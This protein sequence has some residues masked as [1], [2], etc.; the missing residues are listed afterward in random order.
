MTDRHIAGSHVR[1][2]GHG[3]RRRDDK[4]HG[5]VERQGRDAGEGYVAGG[6]K[7]QRVRMEEGRVAHAVAEGNG[8]AGEHIPRASVSERRPRREADAGNIGERRGA[9]DG[10]VV[11]NRNGAVEGDRT[12]LDD[13]KIAPDG[14]R[15]VEGHRRALR[16]VQAAGNVHVAIEYHAGRIGDRQVLVERHRTAKSHRRGI[17]DRQIL[18]R[19]NVPHRTGQVDR[20]R[21]TKRQAVII[22]AVSVQREIVGDRKPARSRRQR[23]VP[24][25][26]NRITVRL[27]PRRRVRRNRRRRPVPQNNQP[28]R[29]DRR[30]ERDRVPSKHRH[31][32]RQHNRRARTIPHHNFIQ[33]ITTPDVYGAS[34]RQ[35]IE[36]TLRQHQT[37]RHVSI[38]RQIN[39]FARR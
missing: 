23:P 37:R 17:V 18:Q 33:K 31:R 26:Q 21:R 38:L 2:K 9:A 11:R 6:A 39:V 35:Q 5:G 25:Y 22:A 13:D 10:D 20:T 14:D 1:A 24:I 3:R 29:N 8:A 15:P 36:L 12:R 16:N 34:R 27:A 19:I 4:R 32:T 28:L 30:Q 7:V